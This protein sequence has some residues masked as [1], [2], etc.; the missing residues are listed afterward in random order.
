[1]QGF[2]LIISDAS[3]L[4]LLDKIN[5]FDVLR[6]L[7]KSVVRTPEVKAEFG[8]NLPD[9]IIIKL[10]RDIPLMEALNET[11]DRGEA[12]A[13][14]LA[15]EIKS[16]FVLIDDLKGR[17]LAKRLGLNFMGVLGMLL[18][19]KEH[20]IIQTVAPYINQIQQT[21]FRVTQSLIDYVL[22]QAGE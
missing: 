6:R 21:D 7:S 19:A 17:K 12:S 9:W 22:E 10:V 4:I 8:N 11:V 15:L 2:D 1:M 5:A 16:A 20:N 3:C 14:A 13:I 18:K